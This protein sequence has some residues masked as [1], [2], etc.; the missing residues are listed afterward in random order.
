MNIEKILSQKK[1]NKEYPIVKEMED[2]ITEIYKKNSDNDILDN[3]SLL[4]EIREDNK[5]NITLFNKLNLEKFNLEEVILQHKEDI[6]ITGSYIRSVLLEELDDI[7]QEIFISTIK[8]INW[9]EI[10]PETYEETETM[11]LKKV[12]NNYVYILKNKFISVSSIILNGKYLIRFG[13][14]N[15]IFYASPMFILEYNINMKYMKCEQKDPVF[16]TKLDLFDNY[17]YITDKKEDIF[18]IIDKKDYALLINLTSY[19]LTKLKDKLTCI[20]YAINLYTLEECHIISHQLKLII[21]ELHKHII[22]KRHPAFFAEI[23]NLSKFDD[24]L[25]TILIN[26]EYTDIKQQLIPYSNIDELNNSL[27][28]YYIKTDRAKEFYDYIKLICHK[29]DA[30]IINNIIKYKPQNII[31]K[32]INKNYLSNYNLYKIILLTSELNYI[33]YIKFNIDIAINFIDKIIDNCLIK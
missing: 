26:Q 31:L 11:F 25:F 5:Y 1:I 7:K 15:N 17:N 28:E 16:K 4:Y 33:K 27:L 20:E 13:Y 24:S 9:K 18:D 23:I 30:D 2:T 3:L 12:N 29:I 14:Y 21:L 22:F 6:V 19:D 10:L 32:G 8:D